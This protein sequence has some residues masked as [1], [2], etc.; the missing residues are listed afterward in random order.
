MTEKVDRNSSNKTILENNTSEKKE[1]LA[2]KLKLCQK[3]KEEYLAG[4]Q[5]ARA[6]LLNYKKEE[7]ERVRG[8]IDKAKE[9]ILLEILPILDNFDQAIKK[10]PPEKVDKDE[11]IKGLLQ[12]R[13]QLM[14][15]LNKHD[16]SEMKVVG[17]KFDPRFHDVVAV[18]EIENAESDTVIEEVQKGYTIEDRVLRPAKVKLAKSKNNNR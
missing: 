11:D 12:I 6:D 14:T 13:S 18:E 2:E 8:F 1:D 15:F 4:W 9:E 3:E 7:A 5:R 16:I 17:E 10:I